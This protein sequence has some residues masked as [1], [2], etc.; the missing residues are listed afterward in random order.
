[1]S[2]LKLSFIILFVPLLS[3]SKVLIPAASTSLKEFEEY[4]KKT[5]YL[6]YSQYQLGL[7]NERK[8]QTSDILIQS[9]SWLE[10]QS[11]YLEVNST[12]R[13]FQNEYSLNASERKLLFNIFEKKISQNLDSDNHKY[14]VTQLCWLYAND[15]NLRYEFSQFQDYCQFKKISF[16]EITKK[17]PEYT[18]LISDGNILHLKE[19]NSLKFNEVPQKIILLSDKKET[20]T[21]FGKINDL[22]KLS[23]DP[24]QVITTGTCD[25]YDSKDL[26][27][28]STYDVYFD[29]DCIQNFKPK[30]FITRAGLFISEN[31]Y[32]IISGIIITA[33]IYNYMKDKNIKIEDSAE[34]NFQKLQFNSF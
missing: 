11:R 1:M 10:P 2:K 8:N 20:F 5:E 15:K 25:N 30:S 12:L 21:Y 3:F 23:I 26:N 31:K 33:I 24:N 32:E 22:V 19:D 34:S 4:I 29:S 27:D 18:L 16:K 13:K 9:E 6:S 28:L 14:Y 17:F 7:I